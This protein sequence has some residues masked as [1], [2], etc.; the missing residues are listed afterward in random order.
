MFLVLRGIDLEWLLALGADPLDA[1]VRWLVHRF[2]G[3]VGLVALL[4]AVPAVLGV[5][6]LDDELLA[7]VLAVECFPTA[8]VVAVPRAVDLLG[9]IRREA[10]AAGRALAAP[11][12]G[13]HLPDVALHPALGL[14]PPETAV[15]A[16]G[17]RSVLDLPDASDEHTIILKE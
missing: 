11:L 12:V 10:L 14:E 7:A 16:T 3:R 1:G 17:H 13:V 15:D 2:L 9:V 5:R 8:L 6:L 4:R